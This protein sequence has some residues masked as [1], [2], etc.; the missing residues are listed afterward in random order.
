MMPLFIGQQFKYMIKLATIKEDKVTDGCK[1]DQGRKEI[2][3]HIYCIWHPEICTMKLYS[4]SQ[5]TNSVST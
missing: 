1:C 3:V 2:C 5:K 4:K